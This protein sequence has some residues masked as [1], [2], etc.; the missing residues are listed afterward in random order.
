MG[1]SFLMGFFT[2]VSYYVLYLVFPFN[3]GPDELLEG[4]DFDVEGSPPETITEEGANK[5][6]GG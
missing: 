5:A 1:F 6:K 2:M 4:E 3:T